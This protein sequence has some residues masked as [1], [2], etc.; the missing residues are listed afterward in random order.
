MRAVITCHL[1]ANKKYLM[2]LLVICNRERSKNINLEGT[3]P[4]LDFIFY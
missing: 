4:L 1:T 3:V 2:N